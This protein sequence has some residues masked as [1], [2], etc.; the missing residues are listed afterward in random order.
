MKEQ[1]PGEK[2]INNIRDFKN[3][4]PTKSKNIII[5]RAH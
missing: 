5:S 2:K 4:Q 3:T 1:N